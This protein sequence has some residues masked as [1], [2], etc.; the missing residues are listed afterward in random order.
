MPT[1]HHAAAATGHRATARSGVDAIPASLRDENEP[2]TECVRGTRGPSIAEVERVLPGA[3]SRSGPSRG[4]TTGPRRTR[5]RAQLE[6]R[7]GRCRRDPAPAP[8][9]DQ[10]L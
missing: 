1:T 10:T 5:G 8:A 6:V 3:Q 7:P 2:S 9:T 4:E